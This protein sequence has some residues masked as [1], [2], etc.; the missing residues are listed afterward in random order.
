MLGWRLDLTIILAGVVAIIYT[1]IGGTEAVSLT[2]QYQ[3]AVIFGGMIMAFI[4]LLVKLPASFPDALAVA[5]GFNKLRAV[6]FSLDVRERY[7]LWSG[8][9]GG[10]FLQLSYFGTDQ[11]QV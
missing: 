5:G 3:M 8:L 4:I 10:L 11:S 2:Q 9:L 7:T 1:S 6:T